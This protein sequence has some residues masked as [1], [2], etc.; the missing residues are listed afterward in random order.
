MKRKLTMVVFLTIFATV[1]W[2]YLFQTINTKDV[3]SLIHKYNNEEIQKSVTRNDITKPKSKAFDEPYKKEADESNI[4]NNEAEITVDNQSVDMEE[5]CCEEENN[6]EIEEQHAVLEEEQ[7]EFAEDYSEVEDPTL[8]YEAALA[9]LA[10]FHEAISIKQGNERMIEFTA[11]TLDP[12][13]TYWN[14]EGEL[15]NRHLFNQS[16]VIVL[17]NLAVLDASN[18]DNIFNY[19]ET[20][21]ATVAPN[22]VSMYPAKHIQPAFEITK[23]PEDP[24]NKVVKIQ[25]KIYVS[26]DTPRGLY[27]I[28]AQLEL[29]GK[30]YDNQ[31]HYQ[32]YTG[33]YYVW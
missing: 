16:D 4:G 31:A 18:G 29:K 9:E 20:W 5:T 6:Y 1:I 24:L 14:E 13:L 26:P 23:L 27:Y 3:I 2:Y 25:L 15:E 22:R 32:N 19:K 7:S 21:D 11:S 33:Y 10:N 8:E 12:D 30:H 17:G 28:T